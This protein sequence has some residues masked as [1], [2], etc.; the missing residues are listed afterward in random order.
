MTRNRIVLQIATASKSFA[1]STM[2]RTRGVA[3]E[4]EVIATYVLRK[5]WTSPEE[6]LLITTVVMGQSSHQRQ[7]SASAGRLLY[8]QLGSFRQEKH[9][10]LS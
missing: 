3:V 2:K 6:F 9:I 5:L 4:G 8:A 10:L 7:T 1:K